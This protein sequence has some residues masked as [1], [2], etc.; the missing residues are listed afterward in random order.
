M[1]RLSLLFFLFILTCCAPYKPEL[2]ETQVVNG[3]SI[4]IP[5]D[6]DD[7]PKEN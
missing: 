7:L 5:P 1:K 6:F 3:Q 2:D 4:I